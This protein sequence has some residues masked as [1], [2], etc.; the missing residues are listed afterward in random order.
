[1]EKTTFLGNRPKRRG[2]AGSL[3]LGEETNIAKNSLVKSSVCGRAAPPFARKPHDNGPLVSGRFREKGADAVLNR[4]PRATDA[5]DRWISARRSDPHNILSS[6]L[7][8]NGTFLQR[9]R[10]NP[11]K[12][13]LRIWTLSGKGGRRRPSPSHARRGRAGPL[14]LGDEEQQSA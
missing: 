11:T 10:G 6:D 3:D 13:P 14:D 8:I 4:A 2:R 12:L 7:D 9:T 1:M 5:L